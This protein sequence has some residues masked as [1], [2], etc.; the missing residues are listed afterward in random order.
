MFRFK[1]AYAAN[2][3]LYIIFY[4]SG[5]ETYLDLPLFRIQDTDPIRVTYGMSKPVKMVTFGGTI[6]SASSCRH[7][8][9][10][11]YTAQRTEFSKIIRQL[12]C[13]TGFKQCFDISCTVILEEKIG[14]FVLVVKVLNQAM[15]PHK[16]RNLCSALQPS[17]F[18]NLYVFMWQC[19]EIFFQ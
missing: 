19:H 16:F 3:L 10:K 5:S 2:C 8:T 18:C 11:N 15:E 17:Q 1:K 14:A 12:L 4:G 6:I 7:G 9:E 13:L